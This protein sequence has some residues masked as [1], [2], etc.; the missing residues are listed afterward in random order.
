MVLM[1]SSSRKKEECI[2][3]QTIRIV[4][5]NKIKL[6]KGIRSNDNNNNVYKNMLKTCVEPEWF[7]NTRIH[8]YITW[9]GHMHGLEPKK[10]VHKKEMGNKT[11]RHG[12]DE[13]R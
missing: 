12:G 1:R 11:S 5:K 9:F 6:K 8:A 3:V 13:G 10:R 4:A 7:I 2:L